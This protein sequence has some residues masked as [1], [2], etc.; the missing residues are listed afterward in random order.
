MPRKSRRGKGLTVPSATITTA[1]SVVPS[2]PQCVTNN[3]V[4][5][6]SS[7]HAKLADSIT[8]DLAKIMNDLNVLKSKLAASTKASVAMDT[9]R[10]GKGRKRCSDVLP[11]PSVKKAKVW[12][13]ALKRRMKTKRYTQRKNVLLTR[14]AVKKAKVK[15]CTRKK[16]HN[17]A[18]WLQSKECVLSAGPTIK[19]VP[20]WKSVWL[21]KKNDQEGMQ[22]IHDGPSTKASIKNAKV[23][24]C[25]TKINDDQI[26]DVLLRKASCKNAKVKVNARK[27]NCKQT[28]I[29]IKDVVLPQ[30]SVRTCS[31]AAATVTTSLLC[32]KR[33][34]RVSL[35]SKKSRM[36]FLQRNLVSFASVPSHSNAAAGV[37]CTS[38]ATN[39][40]LPCSVN[41]AS[42]S[43]ASTSTA[44]TSTASTSIASTNTASTST[45]AVF[46][47]CCFGCSSS[48]HHSIN[49]PECNHSSNH[50]PSRQHR[51]SYPPS[52][53]KNPSH[54][55]TTTP[56]F[57][58]SS[59]SCCEWQI[60]S[61]LTHSRY[62]PL[63]TSS[64]PRSVSPATHRPLTSSPTRSVRSTRVQWSGSQS[65]SMRIT[66][67]FSSLIRVSRPPQLRWPP[68]R[69]PRSPSLCS[70]PPA[71]RL[72]PRWTSPRP[73]VP[74][75][76]WRLASR[77]DTWLCRLSCV[78]RLR[79]RTG[80]GCSKHMEQNHVV[81]MTWK[82]DIWQED[83]RVELYGLVEC[84]S[85]A[86]QDLRVMFAHG[87][88][89]PWLIA[90]AGR[91][92]GGDWAWRGR[93]GGFCRM[94]GVLGCWV[95]GG[96][97]GVGNGGAG[98]SDWRSWCRLYGCTNIWGEGYSLKL[99]WAFLYCNT[100]HHWFYK[101]VLF[102][103]IL[104]IKPMVEHLKLDSLYS[105]PDDD[106]L[107]C[108][109]VTLLTLCC[110][111][112]INL[113]KQEAVIKTW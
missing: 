28:K 8:A 13:S 64:T 99:L 92:S 7:D 80:C 74:L 91:W 46:Q 12:Q 76:C 90:R 59:P 78:A 86:E 72:P 21:T 102:I 10:G 24:K 75:A 52:L 83:D 96:Q 27:K 61:S 55:S 103:V 111:F 2:D 106:Y 98:W 47:F 5:N 56:T 54:S 109:I 50:S 73:A 40:L 30:A 19:R 60:W 48:W 49:H 35:F 37:T 105:L 32:Q 88:L 84:M 101:N 89:A 9:S 66:T 108:D 70:T 31:S 14:P 82:Y 16:K 107:G 29:Q 87:C 77:G 104:V 43:T 112:L 67:H 33:T 69:V 3:P 97:E 17:Q 68:T 58:T 79:L 6:S 22:Q 53:P 15:K 42:T 65:L 95:S 62:L 45:T 57:S 23:K 113:I 94:S 39:S 38:T 18:A 81:K 85:T 41:N 93:L 11:V 71:G 25:I 51:C 44:S 100:S 34:I 4:T 1:G 110:M 26:K 36:Y 20:R 63:W